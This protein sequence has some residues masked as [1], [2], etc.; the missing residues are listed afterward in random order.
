LSFASKETNEKSQMANAILKNLL[1]H[2]STSDKVPGTGRQVAGVRV[3]V[4]SIAKISMSW[5]K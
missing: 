5:E 4:Q 3:V 1:Q 2:F